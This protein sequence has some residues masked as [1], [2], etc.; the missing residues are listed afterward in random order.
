MARPRMAIGTYGT[1][2]V[3][4]VQP[5]KWRARTR[6]RFA[7]GKSRQIE[8]HAPSKAKATAA[9]RHALTTIEADR[10]GELKPAT[11]LRALGQRFLESRRELGRSEGTL[12][13]YG[14]AV[15]AH[16]AP[17]IGDLSVAEAT[18]ERLQKFLNAVEKEAGPGA[19]KNCRSALSGMLGLAVRNG[20]LSHNPVRELERVTQRKKKGSTAIPLDEL[21]MFLQRVREDEKLNEWDTVDLITFMLASGWRVAEVCALEA[22]AID[23]AAGTASVVAQNVRV[24]GRGIVRQEFAKTDKSARTTH[25]PEATMLLLHKRHE[26]LRAD[27]NLIFPTP[28]MRP[29]D[30]SNT[31][32]ELRDRRDGLG[33]PGLSTH[34]FRKSVATILDKAGLSATEIADYLGHENPSM[35][36]DVYMNTIKGSTKAAGIMGQK[37]DGLI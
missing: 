18:P 8:K 13:T 15:T 3:A 34:A 5:G 31:Q 26:R 27:T 35:T 4:E 24:K 30:P 23:F 28:L 2:H 32:R 29:R 20:A 10:G 7:D 21:P 14:Y 16:I 6:Y 1:I 37:L 17:R 12:E 11:H 36:Q 19:A 33:Y 25:L 22:S 9:L